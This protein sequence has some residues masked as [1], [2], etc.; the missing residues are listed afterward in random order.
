MK[1]SQKKII[2]VVLVCVFLIIGAVAVSKGK[3]GA[4]EGM[5]QNVKGDKAADSEMLLENTAEADEAYKK[6]KTDLVFWYE[7]DTYTA[8]LEEAAKCYFA[9]T[10][11][12][13]S[14]E[15][16]DTIDYIGNI[17]DKTMQEDSYPDVYLI[18]GDN[19]EEA[20]LYGLVS[21]N[22]SDMADTKIMAQAVEAS[23]YQGKTLGYPLSYNT[24]LF[25]YQNGYFE[26]A[27]TSLQMMIDYSDQNEPAE[28]VE[29]LLEWDVNDAFYD[30][31]FI[32]NSVTFDKTETET[33]DVVYN[34][35]LYDKDLEF[36]EEILESFS[37]DASKVSEDRI[38]ENFLAGRT[39][40]AIID[41]NSLHRLEGYAY[42]LMPLPSL[43]EE[44]GTVTCAATDMLAVNDFSGKQETAANFAS[45][46]T[47]TM[48]AKLHEMSGHY[49][50]IPSKKPDA[51]ETVANQIYESAVLVPNSQDAKDFWVNLEE[52]ISKYF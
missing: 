9:E 45:Y 35:D 4:S 13:V 6:A 25:V 17:Y 21:V 52:T 7:D 28:N 18:S 34:K 3:F 14:V 23:T 42:E 27:P 49:S 50:V 44:L 12:K 38:I 2:S 16:Q 22:E 32:S 29:Y 1:A 48:S 15:Y 26:E 24:C 46:V 19:L 47:G 31:P 43:N 37:V 36:F 40:S 51:I 20:Y 30:F 10:G 8:F 39:L 33:M 41:T 11:V 5:S